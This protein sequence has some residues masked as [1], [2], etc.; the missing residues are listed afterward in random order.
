MTALL[1]L[2]AGVAGQAAG[3]E[4]TAPTG[5]VWDW[6][7]RQ[8]ALRGGVELP[9]V[10]IRG[11]GWERPRI[12]EGADHPWSGDVPTDTSSAAGG[13]AGAAGGRALS[14]YPVSA[15]G[16]YNSAYPYGG[17]DGIAW[18]GRGLNASLRGGVEL[19]TRYLRG[20]L[21]PVLW[22]AEN[23]P[24]ELVPPAGAVTHKT[25]SYSVN[26]DA[27]Q[28]PGTAAVTKVGLGQSVV[29]AG[30][31]NVSVGV[32]TTPLWLGPAQHNPVLLGTN[33]GGIP[34]VDITLHRTDTPLG[35]VEAMLF[36]G[37]VEESAWFDDDAGNDYR[38]VAASSV[39]YAPAFVPGLTVGF[40]RMV[41][42]HWATRSA[43]DAL[44]IFDFDMGSRLGKDERDQRLSLT[45]DWLLPAAGFNVYLEWGRDD[46]SPGRRYI[47]RAPEHSQAYTVGLRQAIDASGAGFF[48]FGAE[49]TQLILSRDYDID[50]GRGRMGFYGHGGL[51]QGH[52]HLGQILGAPVGPGGAAQRFDL[53][54]IG[55]FGSVGA[56]LERSVRDQDYLYGAPDAGP[57]DIRRMNV[58]L[59]GGLRGTLLGGR[60]LALR[61]EASLGY[62]INRNYIEANDM[63]SF[64]FRL[65]TVIRAPVRGEGGAT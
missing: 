17:N 36:W 28:R 4:L 46:Y 29:R 18:Q 45:L 52:T 51:V 40:H 64:H 49:I 33:A 55:G 63:Y 13:S 20:R 47:L 50:L 10:S 9:A 1:L 6:Y 59:R 39:S 58:E 2:V 44:E 14:I 42:S 65:E 41:F 30:V 24:F 53:D 15:V 32:G 27:Y 37:R 19:R 56:F 23:R 62:N 54:Y 8:L 22:S 16:S 5:G 31:W 60:G 38:L 7:L 12:A 26:V 11:A 25:G 21:A 61:G 43:E 57:G 3:Q 34:R 48:V 35:E